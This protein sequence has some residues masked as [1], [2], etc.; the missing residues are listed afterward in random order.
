[1][2]LRGLDYPVKVLIVL[3]VSSVQRVRFR[4]FRKKGVFNFF[5]FLKLDKFHLDHMGPLLS[6]TVSSG[7][8]S[9]SSASC[10]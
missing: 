9:S 4:I 10:S 6:K 7:G 2:S 1:M 8:T 3:L 5:F